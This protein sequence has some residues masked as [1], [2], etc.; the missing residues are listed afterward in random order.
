MTNTTLPLDPAQPAGPRPRTVGELARHVEG[1]VVGNQDAVIFGVSSIEDAEAGDI[2][3][4]ENPRFL[5]E[6]QRSRASAIIAF[7]D[8]TTP[9][10]PL[11]RVDN[12]RYAFTKILKMFAPPLN[13]PKGI[14]PTAIIGSGAK[15]GTNV[16][17][18]PHVV[19][20]ER[21]QVGD[22]SV[23]MAGTVLGN[24]AVV[25]EDCVLF[26]NVTVYAGCTLGNRVV[27]HAGVVVGADGFGYMRVGDQSIKIPQIGTVT[28]EDDVEVGA[29]STIDRAKTGATVIGARTK[30]D[31]LVHI[32]HNVKIGP[33]CIIVAQVG[34][35]GSCQIGRGA[36]LAGQAGIKDHVTI[37]EGAIIHA[38]AGVFGNIEP[39]AEV[40]GYPARPHRE[41]LR[42]DAAVANLPEYVKRIRTLEKA[43]AELE[44]RLRRLEEAM[45]LHRAGEPA[46]EAV[47]GDG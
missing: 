20:G 17:I 40:S 24:E 46:G 1:A 43:N 47:A 22:R 39:G 2:V 33:D 7:L 29:N 19:V 11:I 8:A 32:A 36:M 9:D 5:S 34:I 21:A 13:A 26:P 15:I 3:F 28:I 6:A 25:G 4:A 10:K 27:L 44:A 35:A 42:M 30:I 18:G 16:S 14:H 38:Q 37:G 23:L 31:N 41:R 45:R 12:P